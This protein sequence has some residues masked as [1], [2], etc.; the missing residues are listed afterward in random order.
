MVRSM[1]GFGVGIGRKGGW[2]AEVTLRTWNH[3]YLSVRT[4]SLGDRPLL[5]AQ[6]EE[7]IRETFRRGE[8]GVWLDLQPDR[9]DASRRLFDP[10]AAKAVVDELRQL[11]ESLGLAE[12]GLAD[13]L[14]AGGFQ[15][16]DE[17]DSDVW[18]AVGEALAEALI[19]TTAS[20]AQEGQILGKELT[21]IL[22]ELRTHVDTVSDRLPDIT[23]ELRHR[24]SER[25]DELQ[26]SVDSERFETE[27]AL[28][29][30]RFDVQ[31]ELVRLR[32]HI[33]RASKLL[34]SDGPLGKELD[35]LCQEMLRE[36]NTTGS[37][38]RDT[39]ISSTVIDMKLAVEQF[40]EQVQNV[41]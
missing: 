35:F 26:V 27:L 11:A 9:E 17:S 40:R 29:V 25:I 7:R 41:E 4:R 34:T 23:E 16:T 3:R 30:D 14:R 21:R 33:D 39:Q 31:E 32:G 18:P 5:Q 6:V 1:T 37:K 24:L 19:Q 10:L 2:R 8:V 22:D 36:V 13:V 38:A 15:T 20:R 12:P 28:L